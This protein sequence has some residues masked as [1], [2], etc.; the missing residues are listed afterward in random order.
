VTHPVPFD[1]L[2]SG[3]ERSAVHLET[4]DRYSEPVYQDLKAG[5]RVDLREAY[6]AWY[7]L[8]RATVARGVS[9][10]RARVVSEPVTDYIRFEYDVT[11]ALNVAAGERVRW[12]PRRR[13]SDLLLPGNDF[14]VFDDRLVRFGHFDG[15][16]EHLDDEL[17]E[18]PAVVRL[19]SD[20]FEQVWSRATDHSAYRPG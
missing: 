8:I 1:E 5:R 14:W 10:R 16:G 3:C 2:L 15:N 20:A 17:T 6:R 11:G 18:D 9:V 4:H 13:A 19:C 12:L 7:D